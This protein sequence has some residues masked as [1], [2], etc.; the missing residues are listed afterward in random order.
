MAKPH[1]VD[2]DLSLK[3]EAQYDLLSVWLGGARPVDNVE[4]EPGVY[5]RI[6]RADGHVVGLEMLEAAARL[7]KHPNSLKNPSF[8][9]NLIAKYS[10][11]LASRSAE[12]AAAFR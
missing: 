11:R 4:I 5:L 12:P 2:D 6:S 10:R 3:Y 8:A 7:H 1:P 9:K